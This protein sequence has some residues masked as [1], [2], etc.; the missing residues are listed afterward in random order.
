MNLQMTGR[1]RRIQGALKQGK[2]WKFS[3][4]ALESVQ[5]RPSQHRRF[6]T[7]MVLAAVC[8]AS[9]ARIPAAV[10]AAN[11]R[12]AAPVF[13][14][15]DSTG[16][17]VRLSDYKGKVV[18][19]DFWATWCHGCKLEIPWFME[20]ESRYKEGGLVVI[21]VS[22]DD[23]GWKSVKPYIEL[24]KMNYPV[25]IGSQD[26][27]KQYGL[28]SMPMTWLIDRQGRIAALHTGLVDK[29]GC[30]DE[31]RKLLQAF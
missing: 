19:L 27:A 2:L 12:K 21:G 3:L 14:L 20:F 6:L 4:A 25:V 5:G 28:T 9:L 24:K 22:M 23:D 30:E 17:P 11:L 18:L 29:A 7:T 31:I 15:T 1:D 10:T 13:T 16:A 8:L 26:L